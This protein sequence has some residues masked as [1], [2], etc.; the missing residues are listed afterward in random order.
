MVQINGTLSKPVLTSLI[1]KGFHVTALTTSTDKP[2]YLESDVK[3]VKADYSSAASLAQRLIG[4]AAVVCLLGRFSTTEQNTLLDAT[5]LA[6]VPWFIASSYG[7]DMQDPYHRNNPAWESKYNMEAHLTKSI[8]QADGRTNFIAINTGMLLDWALDF[9]VFGKPGDVET[10]VPI[11][12][13]GESKFSATVSTEVGEMVAAALDEPERFKNQHVN[14]HNAVITQNQMLH[15][16]R[17]VMPN[18][19][20]KAMPLDSDVLW[21]QSKEAVAKGSR[22]SHEKGFIVSSWFKLDRGLFKVTRNQALNVRSWSEAELKEVI[23]AR[24]TGAE[25]H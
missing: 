15:L 7:L 16:C 6:G 12:D 14:V 17:E 20:W 2:S 5:I 9:G 21:E 11:F 18:Q 24:L 19:T 13:G 8:A 1:A 4:H 23:R 22:A 25:D 10:V 3:V